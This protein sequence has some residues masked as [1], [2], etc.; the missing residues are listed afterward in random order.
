MSPSAASLY[1]AGTAP[2]KA[3]YA[4]SIETRLR[5]LKPGPPSTYIPHF[6]GGK[7]IDVEELL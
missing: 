6:H 3:G 7:C 4:Q 2:V 1:P 5:L